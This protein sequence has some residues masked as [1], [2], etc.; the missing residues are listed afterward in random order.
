MSQMLYPSQKFVFR[1]LTGN[2]EE[3]LLRSPT[4]SI[5]PFVP[6]EGAPSRGAPRVDTSRNSDHTLLSSS[7]FYSTSQGPSKA[8]CVQFAKGRLK[9]QP[10]QGKWPAPL[11]EAWADF[12]PLGIHQRFFVAAPLAQLAQ[13]RSRWGA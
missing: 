6:Q 8:D 7:S 2:L 5:C 10:S 13:D 11:K 4:V 12:L 3:L 9:A 1:S